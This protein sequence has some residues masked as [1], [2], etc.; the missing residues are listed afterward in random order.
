MGIFIPANQ[1]YRHVMAQQLSKEQRDKLRADFKRKYPKQVKGEAQNDLSEETE[2][3]L[4]EDNTKD[5]LY[6]EATRLNVKGRSKMDKDALAAAV[7]EA[8]QAEA[9]QTEASE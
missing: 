9:E 4:V 1:Q 2:D 7:A 6:E 5:E 3:A 8:Q